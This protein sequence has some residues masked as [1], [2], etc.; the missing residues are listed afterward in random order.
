MA[1]FYVL[2]FGLL[3]FSTY[4]C[5]VQAVTKLSNGSLRFPPIRE[6]DISSTL[7]SKFDGKGLE[8]WYDFAKSFVHTVQKDDLPYGMF[9]ICVMLYVSNLTVCFSRLKPKI[10]LN[11]K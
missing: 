11:I 8:P 7:T 2:V 4:K 1:K 6:V 5:A 3:C 9:E 10:S